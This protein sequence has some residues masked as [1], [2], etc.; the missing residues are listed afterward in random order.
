MTI[1][2]RSLCKARY[3]TLPRLKLSR[4]QSPHSHLRCG[5]R[6]PLKTQKL[7]IEKPLIQERRGAQST[8]L[9]SICFLILLLMETAERE[10]VGEAVRE[11]GK[12]PTALAVTAFEAKADARMTGEAEGFVAPV[13]SASTSSPSPSPVRSVHDRA[14]ENE[15]GGRARQSIANDDG[16]LMSDEDVSLCR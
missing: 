16:M 3:V 2:R 14:S 8:W 5:F 10:H 7:Q 9:I 1:D 12:A 15:G 13:M 6:F 11:E 4:L